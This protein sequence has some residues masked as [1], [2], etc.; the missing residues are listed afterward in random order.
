MQK[1]DFSVDDLTKAALKRM[2]QRLLV[3][4]EAEEKAIMG[5]IDKRARKKKGDRND[6]AD[7][8]EEGRGK[9]PKIEIEDDKEMDD[10]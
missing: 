8:A 5:E 7:L 3:A 4:T 2:V 6:L 10:D 9:A 1:I